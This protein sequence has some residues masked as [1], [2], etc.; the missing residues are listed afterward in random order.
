MGRVL[1]VGAADREQRLVRE[2]L[3]LVEASFARG[4]QPAE[5]TRMPQQRGLPELLG[6]LRGGVDLRLRPHELAELEQA[7]DVQRPASDRRLPVS[8]QVS[9][10]DD[11]AGEREPLV[12]VVG[13]P[14]RRQLV[15]EHRGEHARVV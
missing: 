2:T 6:E 5:Q 13:P 12:E 7:G 11:L 4:S 14:G 9:E 10:L 1:L 3:G 8:R 15:G